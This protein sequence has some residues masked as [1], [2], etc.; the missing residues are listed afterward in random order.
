MAE[1]PVIMVTVVDNEARGLDMGAA[2]YLIKPV[3]R[4]RLAELIE[5][6]RLA[7]S[8]YISDASADPYSYAIHGQTGPKTAGARISKT[9]RN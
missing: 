5:K 3:N 8:T 7:R 6:H 4:D 2:N 1:I 9:R